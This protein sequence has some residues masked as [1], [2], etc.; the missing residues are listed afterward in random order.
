MLG[1]RFQTQIWC[2][3]SGYDLLFWEHRCTCIYTYRLHERIEFRNKCNIN[4]EPWPDARGESS[5]STPTSTLALAPTGGTGVNVTLTDTWKFEFLY[6]QCSYILK[7]RRDL[8]FYTPVPGITVH[9]VL[10]H[11]R[12][13][14]QP[15][16]EPKLFSYYTWHLH[17]QISKCHDYID[18]QNIFYIHLDISRDYSYLPSGARWQ[19]ALSSECKSAYFCF[20]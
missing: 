10:Y 8:D 16:L 2:V 18:T 14:A 13:F 7:R 1:C 4:V 19:N 6:A 17:H 11:S 15:S 5:H 9:N 12:V 20:K 3:G